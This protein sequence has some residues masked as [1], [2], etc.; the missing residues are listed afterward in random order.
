MGT[1]WLSGEKGQVE[2][3]PSLRSWGLERH[4]NIKLPT[5]SSAKLP[6]ALGALRAFN[7]R[8]V[9]GLIS[10]MSGKCGFSAQLTCMGQAGPIILSLSLYT[11]VKWPTPRVAWW[12]Y[13]MK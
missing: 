13:Y 9:G 8:S 3:C 4:R 12:P 7:Y 6:G 2:S 1:S 5:G 10:V 11:T